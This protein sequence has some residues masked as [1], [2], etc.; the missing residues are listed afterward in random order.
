ML[1]QVKLNTSGIK[2]TPSTFITYY[3]VKTNFNVT[4]E[5]EL[6]TLD[7]VKAVLN[8]YKPV[9]EGGSDTWSIAISTPLHEMYQQIKR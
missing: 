8:S 2:Y 6:L 7:E 1:K 3:E 9:V 4:N 5:Q